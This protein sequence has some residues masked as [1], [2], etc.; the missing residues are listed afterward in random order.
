MDDLKRSLEAYNYH[1]FIMGNPP[2]EQVIEARERLHAL[3]PDE[4]D[5]EACGLCGEE[6]T[7]IQGS[8]VCTNCP[9]HM[10]IYE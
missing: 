1:H 5:W 6:L 7:E 10:M 8:W 2:Y 3:Y 4:R 9:K